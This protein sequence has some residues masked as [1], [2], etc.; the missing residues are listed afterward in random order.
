MNYPP[1]ICSHTT[2]WSHVAD[3][4][5][6]GR[7]EC[8][9]RSRALSA[10]RMSPSCSLPCIVDS[11]RFSIIS[12]QAFSIGESWD[13]KLKSSSCSAKRTHFKAATIL[14]E[15]SACTSERLDMRRM[16]RTAIRSVWVEPMGHQP[17]TAHEIM[18]LKGSPRL[19]SIMQIIRFSAGRHCFEVAVSSFS[20]WVTNRMFSNI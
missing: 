17:N 13:A 3:A 11:Q 2:P 18:K 9:T 14:S 8:T 16:T 7:R 6:P 19:R 15:M 4:D 20:T 1:L 10:P 5:L 12:T